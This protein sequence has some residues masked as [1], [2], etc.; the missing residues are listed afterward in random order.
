MKINASTFLI[1]IF[2]GFSLH[3]E[4]QKIG[5]PEPDFK[6]DMLSAFEPGMDLGLN[7][8][9]RSELMENNSQFLDKVVDIAGGPG[10]DT[11]KMIKINDMVSDREDVM[12]TILGKDTMKKYRKQVKKA[13]K[14]YKGKYKLAKLVI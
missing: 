3:A 11:S 14:P 1:V 10:T 6:K 12:E 9:Q 13:I 4:G 5:L 7:D 2:L 8:N